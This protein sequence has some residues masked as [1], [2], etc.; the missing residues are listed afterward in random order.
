M[1]PQTATYLILSLLT[2]LMGTVAFMCYRMGRMSA[3]IDEIKGV[4]YRL[5]GEKPQ[6]KSYRGSGLKALLITLIV[7]P[8]ALGSS[9]NAAVATMYRDLESI[10]PQDRLYTRYLSIYHIA[11]NKE[12]LEYRQVT[13]FALNSLSRNRLIYRVHPVDLVVDKE[14]GKI[15]QH[16]TLFRISLRWYQIPTKVWEKLVEDEVYFHRD[17]ILERVKGGDKPTALKETPVEYEWKKVEWEGGDWKN[18]DGTTTYYPKGAFTYQ[19]KVP[20]VPDQVAKDSK[21]VVFPGTWL[22]AK[23]WGSVVKATQSECPIVRADWFVVHA[24]QQDE[25]DGTGYYDFLQIKN[26]DDADLLAALDRKL[27]DKHIEEI[28]AIIPIS[29]VAVN[30]RQIARLATI[31]GGVWFSLDTIRQKRRKDNLKRN[32]IRNLNGDLVHDAEEGYYILP[33]RLYFFWAGDAKGVR[34]DSVPPN[35]ASDAKTLIG[36]DTRIH[37]RNCVFC[38]KQGL[39]PLADWGRRVIRSDGIAK[40]VGPVEENQERLKLLYLSNLDKELKLDQDRYADALWQACE[41]KPLELA[42]LFKKVHDKYLTRTLGVTEVANELGVQQAHLIASLKKY[43]LHIQKEKGYGIDPS[44]VGL[45]ADP[46]EK[47][48]REYFK[49]V[50]TQANDIVMGLVLV[51]EPYKEVFKP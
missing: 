46:Q 30:G 33:N 3:E 29:N 27:V 15:V 4:L 35:V 40:L 22:D 34:Q 26:R 38:H 12:R 16:A 7:I 25:R 47:M 8:Y 14:T 39:Q 21:E 20:K 42:D 23:Q 17:G 2:T 41:L 45:L 36:N 28:R 1:D 11:D 10:P 24:F 5:A 37:P 51:G 18:E 6:S 32:V 48:R 43:A 19:K 9:P 49:E 50:F 13:D 31:R 44:L